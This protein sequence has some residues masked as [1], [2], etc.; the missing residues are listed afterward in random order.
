MRCADLVVVDG[1]QEDEEGRGGVDIQ[2]NV[3][4]MQ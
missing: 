2:F 1:V 4:V 3:N